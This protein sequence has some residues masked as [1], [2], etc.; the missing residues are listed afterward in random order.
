MT[1]TINELKT[2]IFTGEF[3]PKFTHSIKLLPKGHVI[4]EDKSVKWNHE[5][6]ERLN[7]IARAEIAERIE[8]KRK[9]KVE[10]NDEIIKTFANEFNISEAKVALALSHA[11]NISS[12]TREI[13][14]SLEETLELFNEMNSVD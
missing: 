14:E 10:M 12:G 2:A 3:D 1:K 7:E 4:D 11:R 5:E 9:L 13:L 8:T 6:V